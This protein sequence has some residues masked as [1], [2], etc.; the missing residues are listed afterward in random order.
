MLDLIESA[1]YLE[2]VRAD[3]RGRLPFDRAVFQG[4]V[5]CSL[6]EHIETTG[7]VWSELARVLAPRA[8]L[9][10][11]FPPNDPETSEL[12]DADQGLVSH[13]PH[14]LRRELETGG[15]RWL[16]ERDFA[17]YRNGNKGWVMHRLVQAERA[18]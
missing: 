6:F 14:T 7:P 15:F 4:A 11:T 10:F 8:P 3:C 16:A 1:S 2:R 17:A 18:S 13:D 12:F 9:I 5:A